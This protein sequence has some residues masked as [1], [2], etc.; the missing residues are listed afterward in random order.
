MPARYRTMARTRNAAVAERW[1]LRNPWPCKPDEPCRAD[2]RE[3]LKS[4][5]C[6]KPYRGLA[7]VTVDGRAL[8]LSKPLDG[9]GQGPLGLAIVIPGIELAD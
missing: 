5:S 4:W 9:I 1:A 8:D 2:L 6:T 3:A 7:R